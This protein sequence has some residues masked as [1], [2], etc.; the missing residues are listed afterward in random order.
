MMDQTV[1]QYV[2]SF[3]APIPE[4]AIDMER[5]ARQDGVPII[6]SHS[7][8]FFHQLARSTQ[9]S[10]IL[11]IGTAIG[12]SALRLLEACP[13]ALITTLE[14]DP[15]MIQ[16]AHVNISKRNCHDQID[17][18]EG[19]ALEVV[20]KVAEK[21]PFD[22]IFID[23]AKGQYQ[24]FFQTFT[25]ML[26]EHGVVVTDNVLFRGLAADPSQAPSK[27]IQKMA[28]KIHAF[29]EW[30]MEHPNYDT[31]MLPIGDGMAISTKKK[32]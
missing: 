9:P 11:E 7:M 32:N 22:V 1:L 13:S 19:D 26:K 10:R 16:K 29:N 20:D 12:Y 15:D 6:D 27:R 5:E 2:H 14:R 21:A 28:E 18:I 17:L 3:S 30:L 25:P 8:Q 23:A 24:R 4:W 31:T